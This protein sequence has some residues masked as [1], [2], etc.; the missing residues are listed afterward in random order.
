MMLT[1]QQLKRLIQLKIKINDMVMSNHMSNLELHN[2]DTTILQQLIATA[3]PFEILKGPFLKG[4]H[5]SG[6]KKAINMGSNCTLGYKILYLQK[7]ERIDSHVNL[8]LVYVNAYDKVFH[9]YGKRWVCMAYG[10]LL[11]LLAQIHTLTCWTH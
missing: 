10:T 5:F 6:I 4:P 9:R 2:M 3:M 7:W 11:S 8:R 1:G